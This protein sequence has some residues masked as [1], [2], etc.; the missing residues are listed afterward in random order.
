MGIVLSEADD[1][2]IGGG[3]VDAVYYQGEKIWPSAPAFTP[4]LVTVTATGP[5][6]V[7]WLAGATSCDRVLCGAGGGSSDGT[8]GGSTTAG[9]L[10]ATGGN[11]GGSGSKTGLSPG[12][13]TYNGQTYPGGTGGGQGV[14][15]TAPGGGGGG[16]YF[17]GISGGM[18][19][20]WAVDTITTP[21]TITGTVGAGGA[22]G[23]N[24]GNGGDGI[25][26]FWFY[27]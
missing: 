23:T 27:T 4:T 12:D 24:A 9:A 18:A 11:A 22:A 5:F 14:N 19:G 10:T 3:S 8:A 21:G 20:V 1:I 25:A 2:R 7:E 6:T 26:H 13:K 16:S 15:G 17:P